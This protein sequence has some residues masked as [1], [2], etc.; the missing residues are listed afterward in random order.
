MLKTRIITA[1]IGFLIAVFAITYGGYVF[2]ALLTILALLGWREYANMLGRV[3]VPVARF[4]GYFFIFLV[5]LGISTGAYTL[6]LFAAILGIIVLGLWYIFD[7]NQ[8]NLSTVAHSILGF[9][10]VQAGFVALIV[11]RSNSF[12]ELV[13]SVDITPN[14]GVI[15]IWM[16]LLCTWASDTFAYFAGYFWGKRHICPHISPKK[17]LEG[18]VGG[19]VGCVLVGTVYALTMNIDVYTGAVIG[20]LIGVIAPLGDLFESKMK[21]NCNIKDSGVLLPGHGGVLDRFD[22]LL[23]SA[24]LIFV[25]L[26][27]I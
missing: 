17:T 25:Y 8:V 23:F 24:P 11:M 13:R 26:L 1:C 16:I 18:F 5:M 10:Y 27:Y 2:N 6:S 9:F 19:F 20:I 3:H 15:F 12:Y 22:S 14:T 21:R 7:Q 4:W